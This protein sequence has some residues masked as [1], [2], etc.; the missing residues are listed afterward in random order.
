MIRLK[1]AMQRL[2]H[3]R[4]DILKMDIEGAEYSVLED[5]AREKIPVGQILVEFHHRLTSVGTGK[6]KRLLSVLDGCGLKI[7]YICPRMEVFTL[8]QAA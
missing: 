6:T 4:I 2:G 1:T 7:A 3:S 5:I 8:V